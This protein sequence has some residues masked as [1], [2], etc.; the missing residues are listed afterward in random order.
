M[1]VHSIGARVSYTQAGTSTD[2]G[3]HSD[4]SM[5]GHYRVEVNNLAELLALPVCVEVVMT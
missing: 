4:P 1:E 2:P 5:G 3:S